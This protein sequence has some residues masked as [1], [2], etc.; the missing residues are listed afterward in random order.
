M[1]EVE[2]IGVDRVERS[3]NLD[4][5][6]NREQYEY[7]C[8]DLA[9]SDQLH[10]VLTDIDIVI[11]GAATTLGVRGY[12][13]RP[14]T[15]LSNDVILHR[16]LLK[17]SAAH[18]V[19]RVVYISSSMVYE[20]DDPPHCES[21]FSELELPS[22]DYGLSKAVCER[23][24]RAFQSEKGLN[25]TIWRPFN[26]ITPYER[27]R[28]TSGMAHV[29]SD[30]IHKLLMEKQNPLEIIGNGEQIRS[31]T[32]VG[33]VAGAIANNSAET[34]TMNEAI[35]IGNRQPVSMK[36]LAY[37]IYEI[38]RESDLIK[39]DLDLEFTTISEY[40]NDVKE[41]LPCTKKAEEKINWQ[42]TVNLDQALRK[43]IDSHTL[44]EESHKRYTHTRDS[45]CDN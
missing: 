23:M 31:F 34:N 22:T 20:E 27:S 14:A 15:I 25:Y 33:D 8:I 7:R 9:D 38:G 18:S 37:K 12:H 24:S 36:E 41:R 19:N 2:V 5:A 3:G 26:V 6:A 13:K 35:N 21:D 4:K 43:C 16:N 45:D 10:N 40:P 30:F 17:A 32:W 11:N 29:Y 44:A 28:P 42:P 1:K 39:D